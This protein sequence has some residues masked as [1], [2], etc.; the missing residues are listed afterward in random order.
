MV[1]A[2]AEGF[3]VFEVIDLMKDRRWYVQP[4]LSY[5]PSPANVHFSVTATSLEVVAP[6]LEDLAACVA[7]ARE[8]PAD[9]GRAELLGALRELDPA[10]F[11]PEM[12]GQM[13]AMAGLAGGGQ[14][15]ERMAEINAIMDA[16]PP[17]LKEQLLVAFLNDL[18]VPARPASDGDASHDG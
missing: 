2:Q 16:L 14:L 17:A 9:P 1:A 5:G 8:T 15:P 18:F 12:Y 13:L 7:Q 10:A 11:T 3:D 6:M 4:Q